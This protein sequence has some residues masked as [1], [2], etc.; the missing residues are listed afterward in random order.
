ETP[1]IT[2][3]LTTQRPST[4]ALSPRSESGTNCTL[5]TLRL[6]DTRNTIDIRNIIDR[7]EFH[8]DTAVL[9]T[10][11]HESAIDRGQVDQR[12]GNHTENGD[13]EVSTLTKEQTRIR[14]EED[15]QSRCGEC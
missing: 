4:L 1:K 15:G 12:G 14:D 10:V 13:E 6:G 8:T 7:R 11:D 2:P 5:A 3:L 9:I